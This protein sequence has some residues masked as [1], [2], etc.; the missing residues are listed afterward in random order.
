MTMT[1]SDPEAPGRVERRFAEDIVRLHGR[2]RYRG[3]PDAIEGAPLYRFDGHNDGLT[4]L[5]V[6]ESQLPERYLRGIMGFRLAQFLRLGWM[7]PGVTYRRARYYEQTTST[8]VDCV[9]TVTLTDTGRIVGYLGLLGSQD[10]VGLPLDSPLRC[11]FPAELAHR[12]E[13]LPAFAAPHLNTHHVY[14]LK[15]FIRD[16]S[17]ARGAQRDRVPWHLM[18]GLGRTALALSDE[19]RVGLGDSRENGALRHLRMAGFNPLVIDG[20]RPS[21]PRTELMWP[22]YEQPLL[23]KPFITTVPEDLG[24]YM[25]AIESGL[26]L[27]TSSNWQRLAVSRLAAVRR[28]AGGSGGGSGATGSGGATGGA[29]LP[30]ARTSALSAARPSA[31]RQPDDIDVDVDVNIDNVNNVKNVSVESECP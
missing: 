10:P 11:R 4:T 27:S 24:R 15:R 23:A 13:L 19:M 9:H 31:P 1:I 14:E 22:S 8:A 3:L 25:D 28:T 26:M 2:L 30:G 18:L 7:D 17:M 20:T 12:V 5:S 6:R 29:G 16:P 21:L